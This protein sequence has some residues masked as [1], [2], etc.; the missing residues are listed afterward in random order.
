[1]KIHRKHPQFIWLK[2]EILNV[3]LD[4][5]CSMRIHFRQFSGDGT[6]NAHEN[7]RK[8]LVFC[9]AMIQSA[10]ERI[11]TKSD[12]SIFRT[13]AKDILLFRF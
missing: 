8:R 7:L 4:V 5:L 6:L 11:Q 1:M 3:S 2:L 12:F 10:L 9:T 13:L